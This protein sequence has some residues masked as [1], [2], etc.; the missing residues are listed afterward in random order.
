M[1]DP[2]FGY[3]VVDGGPDSFLPGY[4][5]V[6]DGFWIIHALFGPLGIVLACL[7]TV[8]WQ[9]ERVKMERLDSGSPFGM[10]YST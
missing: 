1:R 8:L 3:S 10:G 2:H 5:T 4:R 9:R 6:V 7:G